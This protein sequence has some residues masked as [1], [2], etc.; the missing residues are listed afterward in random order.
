[1]RKN[2]NNSILEKSQE[3]R[4]KQHERIVE[5]ILLDKRLKTL[6]DDPRK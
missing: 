2:Q 5:I 6:L 3:E 1:M 4:A